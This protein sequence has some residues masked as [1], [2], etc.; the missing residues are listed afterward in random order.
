MLTVELSATEHKLK[1]LSSL[2]IDDIL[3]GGV[4]VSTE[5]YPISFRV[6]G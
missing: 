4:D 2:T 5:Y 1:R 3:C 6:I